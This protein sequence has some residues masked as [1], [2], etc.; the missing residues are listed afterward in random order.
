MDERSTTADPG[1]ASRAAVVR[2]A[3]HAAA[4]GTVPTQ[5]LFGVSVSDVT[6]DEAVARIVSWAAG[7]RPRT[8]VTTNLD[9]VMKLRD[10]PLFTRA[11]READLVT[12]DGMPLVW[13]SRREG[14]PLRER[15]T[16]SDLIE[17]VAREA[18]RAGLSLFLFGSTM[19]R[20]HAAAER[21]KADNPTLEIRGAYAPPQ[22]FERDPE[23]H[24]EV[25][26]I[27]RTVRPHIVLVAVGA[28]KQEIWARAMA[29]KVRRGV[30]VSIGSGL[31]FLS[32]DVRRAPAWMRRGGLEWLWRTL[33]EPVRLGPRYL[34]IIV[35]LPRLY[36]MHRR[37]R[38]LWDEAQRQALARRADEGYRHAAPRDRAAGGN[39]R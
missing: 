22:G 6:L 23:I 10:D 38:A 30:F 32:R 26:R 5:R 12:A 13:L 37:D 39:E 20:L 21:L 1:T 24:A 18:A 36:R 27:I 19:E 11:Y 33:C 17:P 25:A 34:N 9:H 29:A 31:D 15:V 16:G 8:V 2:R 35:H 3:A 7:P 14:Q 4:D 28:P